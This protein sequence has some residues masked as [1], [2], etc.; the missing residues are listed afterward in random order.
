MPKKTITIFTQAE[1]W[2]SLAEFTIAHRTQELITNEYAMY[3]TI[4]TQTVEIDEI[5]INSERLTNAHIDYLR[6]LKS[7]VSAKAQVDLKNLDEQINNLLCLENKG[8]A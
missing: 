8:V 2:G 3:I 7:Q 1:K 5:E 6:S 4:H